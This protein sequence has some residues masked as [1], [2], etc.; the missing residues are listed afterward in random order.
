MKTVTTK[1]SV[2]NIIKP[3][4]ASNS[5]P[6]TI[7][8]VV[9]AWKERRVSVQPSLDPD[10]DMLIISGRGGKPSHLFAGHFVEKLN[11]AARSPD[12]P[13]QWDE[14]PFAVAWLRSLGAR[15]PSQAAFYVSE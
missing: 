8:A 3:S 4:K 7:G 1:A 15:V 13:V 2:K 10:E 6:P 9:S 5:S 12:W 11:A 14:V